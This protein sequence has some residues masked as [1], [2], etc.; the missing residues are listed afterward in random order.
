M[1][2]ELAPELN[3]IVKYMEREKAVRLR[4]KN[5]AWDILIKRKGK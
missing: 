1:I 5:G 3:A 4:V 2:E